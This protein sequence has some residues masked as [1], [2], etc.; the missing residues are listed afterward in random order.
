MSVGYF[1]TG[2]DT[3]VGK[4]LVSCTLIHA[5]SAC[6][7][8]V[9]G[10]KPVAAGHGDDGAWMDVEMLIAA[11]N[12]SAPRS[13]INPYA[14]IRRTAPHIAAIEMGIEIDT[15]VILKACRGLQDIAEIVIVEG[16]G[17]FRVPLNNRH[18]AGDMARS[19]GF[20]VILVVGMRLGCLNH[21]LLTAEAVQSVGLPL[22]GWVANQIDPQMLDFDENVRALQ[23][24][25]TCPLLGVLPFT[26]GVIAQEFTSL[27]D[28]SSLQQVKV[29]T[30]QN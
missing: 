6:G 23:Q 9:V 7:K 17:G 25:L 13:L 3:N 2:T 11:S 20:P 22:A 4:T 12:V 15:A 16:I 27:L 24:R 30:L 19:M 14:L 1:I 29:G 21:A 18:D 26:P 28:I 10:M 8:A 5:L